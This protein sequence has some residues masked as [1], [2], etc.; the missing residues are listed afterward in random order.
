MQSTSLS[1]HYAELTD[2]CHDPPVQHGIVE[3]S[4]TLIREL[5]AMLGRQENVLSSITD[6][7]VCTDEKGKIQWCNHPFA[8]LVGRSHIEIMETELFSI[9][10]LEQQSRTL[11]RR[12]HPQSLALKVR[13]VGTGS[14]ELRTAGRRRILDVSWTH[15]QTQ[16]GEIS[17]VWDIRDVTPRKQAEE[18]IQKLNDDFQ[19]ATLNLL[20]DFNEEKIRT[21]ETQRA[22]LNILEDFEAEKT[23]VESSNEELEAF[24]YSVSHDL[25]AP[26]RAIDGFSRQLLQ[27]ADSQLDDVGKGDL[28][29]IRKAAQRMGQLI[30]DLLNLSRLTR[31]EMTRDYVNLSA[32]VQKV[33]T[34][35]K[36]SNPERHVEWNIAPQV[37]ARGDPRLLLIAVENLLGNAWKFTAKCTVA[38]IAFGVAT[39]KGQTAFFIR[40]NG[41]GFKMADSQRLFGVFQ[42]LHDAREYA[43]TGIG[44]ATVQ[45]IINR[46]GGKIW[47]EAEVNHGA[48]FY[49]TLS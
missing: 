11:L 4:A 46:H 41:A 18:F 17:I 5:R 35:L 40:D 21:G 8:E 45:R 44:L 7:I 42:R 37:T 1:E 6:A 9:L 3:N 29:R 38:R 32:H 28:A 31:S 48:T 14:Y 26:L 43:G 12:Q 16:E 39:E 36:S 27:N 24:S 13:P 25:R 34:D 23:K 15:I 19:R 20:E 22:I 49:F 30:D 2:L 47:V 10:P 33:A